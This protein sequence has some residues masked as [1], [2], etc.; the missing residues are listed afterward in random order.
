[1]RVGEGEIGELSRQRYRIGEV[2]GLVGTTPRTIRYYEELGLLGAEELRP[3]GVHRLYSDTDVARL[4]DIV[5]L[6]DLLGLSLDELIGLAD[7]E[8]ARESL[9]A[10]WD[11]PADNRE[12][13]RIVRESI[14][15]VERQVELVRSRQQHLDEFQ[16]ELTAKLTQLRRRLAELDS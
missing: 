9:R 7:A 5:R 15:L 12:R 6:R 13:A 8:H 3:K 14:S 2:A 16:L 1:M 10:Q 4:R 11:G